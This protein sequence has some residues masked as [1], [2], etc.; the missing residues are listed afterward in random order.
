[1]HCCFKIDLLDS[2]ISLATESRC[3]SNTVNTA[4]YPKNR[5]RA[6]H[7]HATSFLAKTQLLENMWFLSYTV[8]RY[9]I[10]HEAD[11]CKP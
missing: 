10:I 6:Q 3:R 4:R 11:S 5:K 1:M 8:E 9:L 2:E 7:R